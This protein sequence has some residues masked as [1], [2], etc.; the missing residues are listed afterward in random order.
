MNSKKGNKWTSILIYTILITVT[1]LALSIPIF[2][3]QYVYPKFI[4]EL[5]KNT[6]E[7]AVRAGKH[8]MKTVLKYQ[9]NDSIVISSSLATYMD[10]AFEDFDLWKVKLFNNSGKI[11]YSTSAKD[12]GSM[13]E[14]SYFHKVVAKGRIYTKMVEKNTKTLEG[15]IVKNDVIETYFPIMKGKNFIGAFELYY[16]VT[17]RRESM[18]GL[19]AKISFILNTLSIIVVISVVFT[20]FIYRK[21]MKDR[22]DFEIELME[23]AIKD[24]LTGLYNRHGFE[25]LFNKEFQKCQRYKK[26]A[27]IMLFDIDNFKKVNDTYGHQAGDQVL[28]ALALKCTEELRESDIIG[29]YGGEEFIVLLPETKI[30]GALKVAEKMRKSIESYLIST[31]SGE[32]CITISIGLSYLEKRQDKISTELMVKKADD[33]LYEAKNNGRNQVRCAV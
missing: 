28:S 11:V 23:I 27:C 1:F 22:D 15:K 30:E 33:A 6:E 12:V 10:S 13:N 3:S 31:N 24:N 17:I 14:H 26:H 32:L 18:D 2:R 16:N 20:T 7:E 4:E 25:A 8:M 19:M 21:S 9:I 5:L 29:R